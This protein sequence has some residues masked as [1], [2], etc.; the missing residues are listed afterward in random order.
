MAENP[1]LY[2]HRGGELAFVRRPGR[3]MLDLIAMYERGALLLAPG[4]EMKNGIAHAADLPHNLVAALAV[5]MVRRGDDFRQP[6]FYRT[7]LSLALP[8]GGRVAVPAVGQTQFGATDHR[9]TLLV[10]DG[11]YAGLFVDQRAHEPVNKVYPLMIF[12]DLP[13]AETQPG[14]DP[15]DQHTPYELLAIQ[16]A[17]KDILDGLSQVKELP[18]MSDVFIRMLQ[19][20]GIGVNRTGFVSTIAIRR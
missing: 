5:G 12:P 20:H 7:D 2:N 3:E 11:P 9:C 14:K 4:Q 13:A 10:T 8:N 18:M 16:A 15:Y 19:T 6:P 17:T 1:Y